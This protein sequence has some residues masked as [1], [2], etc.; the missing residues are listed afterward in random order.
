MDGRVP[1]DDSSS[2]FVGES[3]ALRMLVFALPAFGIFALGSAWLNR[4]SPIVPAL[5]LA[6]SVYVARV[7]PWR[8]E[9]HDEGLDLWFPF[10]YRLFLPREVVTV[11]VDPS[12]PVAFVS[13]SR[14]G[15]PLPDG[16]V[17]RR[18]LLRTILAEHGYNVA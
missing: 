14:H 10:G 17:E 11:R 1:R 2:W 18:Q 6:A 5:V 9:V 4:S 15:Y 8:F 3:R 13:S 16:F 12:S 7:L